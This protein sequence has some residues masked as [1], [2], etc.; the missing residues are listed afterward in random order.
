MKKVSCGKLFGSYR[1][2]FQV[3]AVAG[4]LVC[5]PGS[6]TAATVSYVQGN[7]AT[8]QSAQTTVNVTF[9][10]V[11]AAGDLNVIV[12]G[13]NNTTSSVGTV[14][15][16]SGNVYTRAVGPTVSSTA[17]SQSIY[18]S[19]NIAA[20]AAGANIVTVTFSPAA[21]FPD[22]RILEYSGADTANPVDVTAAAA[23]SST[24]SNSGAATTTTAADLI[25]GANMVATGTTG[26]GA[27]FTSR[28]LTSPDAD[29]AEDRMVSA[30]G[31]YS[32]VAPMSPS[33]RWVMQMVAF[34][35]AAQ[36]TGNLTISA[37][38]GLVSVAQGS[39][40]TSTITT[41]ISG[42]FNSAINLSASGA[43]TG[44]TVSFN[45]SA[46]AAPGAGTSTMTITVG[47]GTAAGTYPITVTGS[48]GGIQ[49]TTSVLLTVTAAPTFTISAAPST[50][51]VVAGNQ[52]TS[53]ITT[54]ITG[55]FNSAISLSSSGAPNGTSVSF[56][57]SAIAAPGGGTS[58]M[59][60]A[61]G[62]STV[63][64]TYPISVTG[65]GGGIQ[66]STTVTLTVTVPNFS[67]SA[68]PAALGVVQ[69]SQGTSTITTASSGGFN[70]AIALS[71]TGVP[72]G[73]TVAFNPTS[74]AAPGNGTSTMTITV[75]ASTAVG[76]YPITVTGAGG[77]IQQNTTVTLTVAAPSLSINYVQGNSATPQSSP[78]SV[79]VTY[80]AAQTA[81]N[82]N[83]VAVGWNNST[84]TVGTVTDK[85]GNTYTRAVG[86]TVLAGSMSQSIY[87]A[88][89]IV[90]AAV[91]ANAVTVTFSGAAAFPD[92]RILEYSGADP[93][94][95]VDV[96][97]AATGSSTS[98]NSGTATTTT[99]ADLIFGANM[100]ATG[101]TGPG[102]GF[103]NR[104]LTSPDG[105]IAEDRMVTST[106]AYSAVAPLSSGQWIM[107]M[108]A[109]RTPVSTDTQPPTA[110]G[111]LSATVINAGQIN[112]SWTAATDNVGVTQYLVERCQGAGCSTF[113][114]IGSVNGTTLGYSDTGLLPNT[115]Y[116][117]RVRAT[118]AASN[119]GPY[120]TPPATATTPG[121][122]QAPTIPG[123]LTATAAG[124]TQINLS[125]TASTDNVA[126][127]GYLVERCSGVGCSSFARIQT[128]PTNSFSDTGL[129][130]NTS[131]TYH[132]KATDAAGNFSDYSNLATAV[133][134]LTVSNLTAAYGMNEGTGS[135]INDAS[136]NAL[137]GTLQGAAWTVAGKFGGALSFN[138]TSFVDLGNPTAL[139][140]TGSMSLSAWVFA[141]ANPSDDGQIVAKS[142]TSDG[143][144]LKTTPD[145]GARTFGFAVSSSASS[146]T[147][148]YGKTVLALN[149]WYYVTGVYNASAQTLDIY[150]NGV[151]DNGT[152]LGNVPAAQ[153]DAASNAMIGQRTG[154]YNF[155]G[156]IDEVRIYNAAIT[157][158]QIQSD[159]VTAVGTAGP[160]PLVTLSQ[161]SLN[162]GNQSTG[163]TT[164]PQS[165]TVTNTGNANLTIA[166]ITMSGP[167]PG[168]FG[169]TNN[170]GTTLTPNASCTINATFAPLSTGSRTG[171]I[172]ITDNAGSGQQVITLSGT[173]TGFSVS[174]R[175]TAITPTQT[176][177]FT[178]AGNV[179]W[180]VDGVVNGNA[181]S[182]TISTTGL[183]T[184]PAAAG[185]HMVTA[186]TT[187]QTQSASST[188]YI[189]NF[190][191]VYTFHNDN[192]RTGQ[193]L[194]E[195]VLTPVNVN[196]NQFG[197]LFSVPLDGLTYASALY[198]ASVNIPGK[199]FHNVVYVATEHDSV[200]AY[201]ADS[202]SQT[203]LWKA[204]F[205][206]PAAGVTTVPAADTGECCDI[207]N[208]IGITSTPVIDQSTGTLYV[209]A[210]TKENGNYFQRLHALD[211]TSGAE[212]FGGPVVLQGSVPGIGDGTSGGNVAFNAL[213]EN[214]RPG[215][216]LSNGVISFGFASH[217]DN[218]PWHGWVLGYNA[219]TLQQVFA[220]NATP[221]SYGGGVWQS[222]GALGV[223]S[224]GNY[225]F[226]TGNGD[227]NANT[228][229]RDYGDT[230]VKLGPGGTVVDYFTPFDEASLESN[231]FDLSS[232][233]PV[234]LLDMPG[235]HPHLLV[236]AAKSGTIYVVDRDNMGHFHSGN[237]SQI[238]Q[239][240]ANAFN[241]GQEAGN[242]SAP[243][244][245]NNTVYF[246][247]VSDVLKAFQFTNGLLSVSPASTS[248]ASYPNRGG[249][250]SI[251]ANGSGNGILWAIQN[252]DPS[253]GV[254]RAYDANNLSN[255][256]Y[257]SSQAGARDALDVAAKFTIPVVANGKVF[258]VSN[259]QLTVYG[260]LP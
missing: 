123:N 163:G 181:A 213:H 32:A 161:S 144:Q 147:Q 217:G 55:G 255:E 116:S 9:T 168:D 196:Q 135:V 182:G 127:T 248:V 146:I 29:I 142:S 34:R 231:N 141:T 216:A 17:L 40:G 51:T 158:S 113:A 12:V 10:G 241:G 249:V 199:G 211:I 54:T 2:T 90:G 234:L 72:T 101:T 105:D 20:A 129:T 48:G 91:G 76:V 208:E 119:P 214:Q 253:P 111:N 36:V 82:L 260:L 219:T 50:V 156:T 167:N 103:T 179:I 246:S 67:I 128:V 97:A 243:V 89:S 115:S 230:I 209:V 257:N 162:F 58:T 86:P 81:G 202:G 126:V 210:K 64:G 157:P 88:K 30:T 138:G 106:G 132:V 37:S 140:L 22:I 191:G 169:Q 39:Q 218:H 223:D 189:S 124:P 150:V 110:P 4:G 136:G 8:A 15:D 109:F 121:D 13:W 221:D 220:Y 164:A 226:T 24:S 237:N 66:Q 153:H 166:G 14:T 87:Y 44:T 139:K 244:F 254:L 187:D 117:Y 247:A 225:Y 188:V 1:A 180:S 130:P 186:T 84:A 172:V 251:S 184:P 224:G 154:G 5:C 74:I 99:A 258:V 203:P 21:A 192:L 60:I 159:M 28:I 108:V 205:I 204:S 177:Q 232:A 65:S 77:G 63:A 19:K 155:I 193:N 238:V 176:V 114:Q 250:M 174:P 152:L 151:L 42:G 92:I 190:P 125:W 165:V 98:S 59:M 23:G 131:Y 52:G 207:P 137:T 194:N 62:A 198:V 7:S 80:T 71:A 83:V 46:I 233:G 222:G 206:N 68:S 227:F 215:L 61:V 38:P 201:D 170:C 41:A 96:T 26:P 18:Y 185:T 256:L 143:W 27:S 73:T 94:N 183:Y 134:P 104:L 236:S 56:N 25:F 112:L 35:A 212:K 100:V 69:G 197:K 3:I 107:Q 133:T 122:T 118:D 175:V 33:G 239:S 200:Y 120:S 45:P 240:I 95:P 93:S 252:N 53:T 6:L 195:T 242:Y 16:K 148:R 49:Q 75:G 235:A 145:T 259:T 149:T 31:S 102:S 43:P 78:A 173:G 171:N 79:S 70:S 229:G 11:Q 57:P 160:A 178:A 245:F 47:A 85:S 228:G